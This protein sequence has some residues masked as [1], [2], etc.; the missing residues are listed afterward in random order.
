MVVGEDGAL[1]AISDLHVAYA[2]NRAI[3]EGLR[4][5][6]PGDWLLV[7][8]DVGDT[9]EDIEWALG[10]LSRRF[11][12]VVWVPGNHEL[13]TPPADPVTLR[14]EARYRH[15]VDLCRSLG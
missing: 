13:W 12:K 3:V 5:G 10:L 7:A 4:P 8:G 11:A 9:V 2:E 15:L 1:L 6:S 14:G